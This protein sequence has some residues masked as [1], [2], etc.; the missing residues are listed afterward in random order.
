MTIKK[1]TKVGNIIFYIGL[2]VFIF[3]LSMNEDIGWKK[4]YPEDYTTYSMPIMIL[5][6]VIIVGTNFFRKKKQK[7]KDNNSKSNKEK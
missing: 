6:V 3:G 7:D 4:Y 5:G 2:L 1:Y